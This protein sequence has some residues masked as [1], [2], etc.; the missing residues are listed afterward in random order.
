MK[1]H[2]IC[3]LFRFRVLVFLRTHQSYRGLAQSF[4]DG[5]VKFRLRKCHFSNMFVT[6]VS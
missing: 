3:L 6:V 1:R 4:N 2:R 5:M